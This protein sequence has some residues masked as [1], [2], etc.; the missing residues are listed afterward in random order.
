LRERSSHFRDTLPSFTTKPKHR[1]SIH[2]ALAIPQL[3]T[4]S[5]EWLYNSTLN[6]YDESKHPYLILAQ[7]YVSAESFGVPLLC[8][9]IIEV[10]VQKMGRDAPELP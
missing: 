10:F 2:L 9:K 6:A 7:L 5:A 1:P 8:N 3:F 4:I